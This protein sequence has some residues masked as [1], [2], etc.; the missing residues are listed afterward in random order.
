ML[1]DGVRL[2]HV[3]RLVAMMIVGAIATAFV[4][5]AA[6]PAASQFAVVCGAVSVAL[7]IALFDA[8]LFSWV[9]EVE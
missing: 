6:V 8:G 1:E 3:A 2:R 4:L 9:D 7:I 5:L